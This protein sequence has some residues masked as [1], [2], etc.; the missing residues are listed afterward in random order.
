MIPVAP[1][2]PPDIPWLADGVPPI[3]I[4][5]C[6]AGWREVDEEGVITCDPYPEGGPMA[7]AAGE[8]HFPGD[9]ACTVV[10][11]EC[12]SGDFAIDLPEPGSVV[13]VRAS[14]A[15]GG[16]GSVSTPY[17]SLAEVPWTALSA[18][19]TVALAKG[20]YPGV[21]PLASRGARRWCMRGTDDR[22]RG[23]RRGDRRRDRH[24]GRY[25]GVRREHHDSERPHA[26]RVPSARRL[27]RAPRRGHRPRRGNRRARQRDGKSCDGHERARARHATR[28]GNVRCGHSGGVRRQRGSEPRGRRRESDVR[29]RGPCQRDRGRPRRR[30]GDGNAASSERSDG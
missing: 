21:L 20:T 4:A 5:P 25:R 12:P 1:V 26:G 27:A 7:C 22:H 14:A 30:R 6:P 9:P 16:D 10:G 15:G 3:A 2:T 13:Y 8:A 28:G 18:G 24:C 23:R 29:R 19:T 11:A 17:S